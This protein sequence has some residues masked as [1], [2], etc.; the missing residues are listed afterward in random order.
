M[1]TLQQIR[2]NV[3]RFRSTNML[4]NYFTTPIGA[5]L[6]SSGESGLWVMAANP[7]F[8]K[9]RRASMEVIRG[10]KKSE[11]KWTQLRN[12][13]SGRILPPEQRFSSRNYPDRVVWM[14]GDATLDSVAGTRWEDRQFFVFD[15][16]PLIAPFK[17]NEKEDIIIGECGL[18]FTL[19]ITKL[20]G[21]KGKTALILII[22]TGNLDVFELLK[23]RKAKAC[24]SNRMLQALTDYLID[25]GVEVIRRY[26]KSGRNPP[27][28]S[29]RERGR[30]QFKNGAKG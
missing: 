5:L 12:G 10:T 11:L 17:R 22:C 18:L 4:R 14:S 21:K 9:S 8:W 30:V 20:W 6:G 28:I 15:A 1:H 29:C 24:C 23:G 19:L 13:S 2:G 3:E 26:V 27:A 7:D 16:P 25:R